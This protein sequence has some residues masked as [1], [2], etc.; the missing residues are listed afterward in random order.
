MAGARILGWCLA[1]SLGA[2]GA[3]AATADGRLAS[4]MKNRDKSSVRSL[5]T[6]RVDVNAPDVEGMT[7]LH[8]AAHWDDLDTAKLLLRAGANARAANRYG[9][10][11]L[12]EAATLGSARDD[13]DAAQGRRRSECRLRRGGNAVDDRRRGPA[14]WMPSRCC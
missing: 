12:H 4:A 10:T 11:P 13:R 1:V 2:A 9:V 5:L 7:A 6:Q 14:A 8:W 3:I